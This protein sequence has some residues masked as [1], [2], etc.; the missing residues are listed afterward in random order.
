VSKVNVYDEYKGSIIMTPVGLISD[1]NL[2]THLWALVCLENM[3]AKLS[4]AEKKRYVELY[5]ELRTR[6]VEIP[7]GVEI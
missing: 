3:G 4:C 2:I 5:E 6:N 1:E 7:F